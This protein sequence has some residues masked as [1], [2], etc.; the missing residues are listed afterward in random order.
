MGDI[1]LTSLVASPSVD[2]SLMIFHAKHS[3]GYQPSIPTRDCSEWDKTHYVQSLLFYTS[4][5]KG[6][7][8]Y[9][10]RVFRQTGSTCSENSAFRSFPS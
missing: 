7:M 5:G 10:A 2:V 3:F 1:V 4:L 8:V 6:S 9:G